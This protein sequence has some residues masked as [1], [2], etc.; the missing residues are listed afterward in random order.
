[1]HSR[2]CRGLKNCYLIL[3][4]FIPKKCFILLHCEWNLRFGWFG[5]NLNQKVIDRQIIF[6][7]V[8]SDTLEIN[9]GSFQVVFCAHMRLTNMVT[10][11]Q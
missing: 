5:L 11:L 1:M 3:E 7:S 2:S 9:H 10:K 8:L 6:S 4:E